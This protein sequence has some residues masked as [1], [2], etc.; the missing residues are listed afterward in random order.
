MSSLQVT[1]S[2]RMPSRST[3]EPISVRSWPAEKARPSAASTM[4]RTERS[5][6]NRSSAS[7]RQLIMAADSTLYLAARFRVRRATGPRCS[8]RTNG[9]SAALIVR[10]LD[11]PTDCTPEAL[12]IDWRIEPTRG[13]QRTMAEAK[14]ARRVSAEVAAGQ[15]RSGDWVDYGFG[16]GQPDAFD[17]ALAQRADQLQQVKIRSALTVRPGAG[18]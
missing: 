11:T 14:Q 6:P 16:L 5:A 17:R 13:V 3:S 15:V 2:A 1:N 8:T 7:W 12:P 4:A 9:G 18:V 10:L